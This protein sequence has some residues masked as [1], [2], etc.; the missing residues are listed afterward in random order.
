MW[1]YAVESGSNLSH[2]IDILHNV[3]LATPRPALLLLPVLSSHKPESRPVAQTILAVDVG[4]LNAP[5]DPQLATL[6]SSKA[7]HL[8]LNA[9][10]GPPIVGVPNG[11]NKEV[12]ATIVVHIRL[13]ASVVLDFTGAPVVEA[14]WVG[15]TNVGNPLGTWAGAG[16]GVKVVL[17]EGLGVL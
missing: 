7:V 8:G 11:H 9:S 12:A 3:N 1:T 6:R 13:V 14:T 10:A 2:A 17:E 4:H 15:V 5:L 16:A